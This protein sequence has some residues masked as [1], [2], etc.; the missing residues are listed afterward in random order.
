MAGASGDLF[1]SPK[2][3]SCAISR[4]AKAMARSLRGPLKAKAIETTHTEAL[5]L[6][7]KAFGY[8][9]WN[10]PPAENHGRRGRLILRQRPSTACSAAKASMRC[11][12]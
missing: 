10:I 9:N 8:E 5:E 6:I 12:S 11:V 1:R 2:V 4:D 3:L 7:A